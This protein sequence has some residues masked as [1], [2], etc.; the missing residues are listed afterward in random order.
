MIKGVEEGEGKGRE[1]IG[2]K[3]YLTGERE[4]NGVRRL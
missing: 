1:K 4:R 2:M 3:L